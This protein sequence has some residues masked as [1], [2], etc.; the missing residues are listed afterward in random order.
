LDPT[1]RVIL[2][3]GERLSLTPKV[4]DTLVCL[5][6]N[7]GRLLTKD[8]LLKEI[9]PDTFV[10]EVN[11]AVN[12]STLRKAFGEGIMAELIKDDAFNFGQRLMTLRSAISFPYRTKLLAP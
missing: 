5:V 8:K 6:R 3:S 9:W 4:F 12:S 7:G 1:E 10:E 11:L 2:R